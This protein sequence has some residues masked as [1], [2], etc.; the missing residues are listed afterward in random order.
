MLLRQLCRPFL[1]ATFVLTLVVSLVLFAG[2][3]DGCYP[4]DC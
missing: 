2:N 1:G 4:Q 3:S